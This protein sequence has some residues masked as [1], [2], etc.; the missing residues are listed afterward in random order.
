MIAHRERGVGHLLYL[1]DS[2]TCIKP[3]SEVRVVLLSEQRSRSKEEPTS[4]KYSPSLTKGNLRH[5]NAVALLNENG[6]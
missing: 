4:Q 3:L 6:S 5:G 1:A 2:R